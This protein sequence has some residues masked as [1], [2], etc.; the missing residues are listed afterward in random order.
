MDHEDEAAG[1]QEE[2]ATTAAAASM[3]LTRKKYLLTVVTAIFVFAYVGLETNYAAFLTT[4]TVAVGHSKVDG[5]R[6]TAVFRGAFAVM[7]LLAVLT[8]VKINGRIVIWVSLAISFLGAVFL[9]CYSTSSLLWLQI[10][11]GKQQN[12]AQ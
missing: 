3:G 2:K 7:R 11:S 9:L 6:A 1:D 10:C 8:A 4:F 12:R 5:T